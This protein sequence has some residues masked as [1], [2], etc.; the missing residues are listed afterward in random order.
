MVTRKKKIV[1]TVYVVLKRK[2]LNGF[3]QKI[4]HLKNLIIVKKLC[5]NVTPYILRQLYLPHSAF[6]RS[7]SA[8]F[9]KSCTPSALMSHN[10]K[11]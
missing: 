7:A 9:S 8:S 3:V 11:D 5:F 6:R 2:V 4:P 1:I 10:Q